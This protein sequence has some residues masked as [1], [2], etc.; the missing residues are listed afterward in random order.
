MTP[1]CFSYRLLKYTVVHSAWSVMASC[2]IFLW[3][4]VG[5]AICAQVPVSE[6]VQ[7]H[8]TDSFK[9]TVYQK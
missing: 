8:W 4:S 3:S 9:A 7:A 1:L 2:T 5:L 6:A